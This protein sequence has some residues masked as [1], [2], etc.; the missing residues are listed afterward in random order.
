MGLGE[1]ALVH[2]TGRDG[3]GPFCS[4]SF[5]EPQ[6][7]F[8]SFLSFCRLFPPADTQKSLRSPISLSS[9]TYLFLCCLC[10]MT[11]VV[12]WTC[13]VLQVERVCEEGNLTCLISAFSCSVYPVI[14][15]ILA[16]YCCFPVSSWAT[17][18]SGFKPFCL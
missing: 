1:Q 18:G 12:L 15:P 11:P 10:L 5:L 13:W 3:Q 9:I 16:L 7:S 6:S 14:L 17:F 4:L 2:V 8:C